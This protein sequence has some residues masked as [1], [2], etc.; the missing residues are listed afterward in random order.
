METCHVKP[1]CGLQIPEFENHMNRSP[2][3]YTSKREKLEERR[4][5]QRQKIRCHYC[6]PSHSYYFTIV[7]AHSTSHSICSQ[8]VTHFRIVITIAECIH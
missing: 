1:I 8:K 7:E 5:K 6:V 2:C 4:S 3:V